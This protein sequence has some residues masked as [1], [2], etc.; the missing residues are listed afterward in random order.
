MITIGADHRGFLLKE[1]LKNELQKL[2]YTVNDVGTFNNNQV[3]YNDYANKV[4]YDVINNNNTKGILICGSGIGMSIAANRHKNIRCA[5]ITSANRN[6]VKLARQH[7]DINVI[8]FGASIH[9]EMNEM[10]KMNKINEINEINTI[11]NEQALDIVKL[12]LSTEFI[13]NENYIR[14][15]NKLN[16][17]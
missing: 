6:V 11:T 15:N 7:N 10:N 5:N 2:G 3:D 16:K 17:I 9:N 4:C 1:Y 12:F 14:R 8:S 13:N